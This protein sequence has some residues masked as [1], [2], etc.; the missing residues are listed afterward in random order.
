MRM[1][2]FV[3]L[4]LVSAFFAS[5]LFLRPAQTWAQTFESLLV[6]DSPQC[7]AYLNPS[8]RDSSFMAPT[9][10]VTREAARCRFMAFAGDWL[11][12]IGRNLR[13]TEEDMDVTREGTGVVARFVRLDHGSARI[14]VKSSSSVS[15]SY[16][17]I[18]R[19]EEHHFEGRAESAERVVEGPFRRVRRLRV[20][21]I[22][23]F[24][25]GRWVN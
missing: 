17:G 3:L 13:H 18:L 19:Y 16:V 5:G 14:A 2:R 20:T 1:P 9:V 21:E 15:C 25:S 24:V 8:P 22:F 6:A 12:R 4:A 7:V 10:P 23:R 11:V